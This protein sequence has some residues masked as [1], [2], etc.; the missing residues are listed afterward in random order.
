MKNLAHMTDDELVCQYVNGC[1]EAF[2]ILLQRHQDALYDYI[3]RHL[4]SMPDMIDDV[5]QE[6]FVK[7]IMCLRDGNYQPSGLFR[8]W[9]CRIAHNVMVDLF[10]S[11]AQLPIVKG[12]ENGPNLIEMH[13]GT[14]TFIEA[15]LVNEQTLEDVKRI[16][17]ELPEAQRTVV[18][19][20][21][22]EN[23]SFKEIS[24]LTG[25]TLNT[26]LGRMRYGII[27]MRR[28]AEEKNIALELI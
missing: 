19:L 24:D 28:I 21:Y 26:C 9:I 25:A 7:V 15:E 11:E 10:R 20:R 3:S 14:D 5:F 16:M 13:Q 8:A 23:R 4:K 17:E 22:Y 18:Y 1:N 12:D 6:T 2:D 27:N